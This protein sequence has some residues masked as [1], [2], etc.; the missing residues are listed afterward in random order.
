AK[1]GIATL[2]MI[3]QQ[4]LERYGVR[5]NAIAPGA[6]TRL[7]ASVPGVDEIWREAGADEWAPHDPGNVS[8]FVA[9]LATADCPIKGRVFY[10]MGGTVALF[11]PF[12]LV[13]EIKIDRR[14]TVEELRDQAAHFADVEFQLGN[15]YA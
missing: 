10:V 1:T 9:Y 3:A 11:Q 15:P 14:W 7:T 6:A 13:D 8:P 4:E 2:T 12:S 5:C